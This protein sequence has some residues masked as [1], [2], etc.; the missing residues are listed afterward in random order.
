[1]SKFKKAFYLIS[2]ISL[3]FAIFSSIRMI[4]SYIKFRKCMNDI[5]DIDIEEASKNLTKAVNAR[6]L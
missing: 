3:V 4:H 1:M 2:E 6:E 5:Y